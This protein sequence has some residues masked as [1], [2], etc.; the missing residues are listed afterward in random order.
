MDI[1]NEVVAVLDEVLSLKGRASEFALDTPLLGAIPELDSM[2]VVSLIT[3]L[4]EHF[5]FTVEDDEIDGSVFASLA[6]LID[7]VA[8]KLAD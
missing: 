3:T 6:T 4:E 1:R 2:A 7:F 5:G 8:G